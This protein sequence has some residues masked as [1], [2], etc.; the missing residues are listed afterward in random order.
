MNNHKIKVGEKIKDRT[1]LSNSIEKLTTLELDY[2]SSSFSL[3]FDAFPFNYPDQT[4]FRY[5]L[6]GQ[7]DDWVLVPQQTNQAVFSNLSPDDYTFE[8]QASENGRNWS[9]AKRLNL[10]I[11][12]PF[13]KRH[14]SKL[15]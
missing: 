14:G 8:V 1:I 4:I 6:N 2:S 5:R 7:S 9:A 15:Y 12:P 10:S 11:I 3:V 13:I